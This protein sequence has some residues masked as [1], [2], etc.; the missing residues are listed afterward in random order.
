MLNKE[1]TGIV[2]L[3]SIFFMVSLFLG[4][5]FQK[6]FSQSST[7][8]TNSQEFEK[9]KELGKEGY[10]KECQGTGGIGEALGDSIC[11][12]FADVFE[13]EE[14]NSVQQNQTSNNTELQG[15][16]SFV[17]NEYGI[18][19]VYPGDWYQN[20]HSVAKGTREFSSDIYEAPKFSKFLLLG[21]P[22]F[23]KMW[24]DV[25]KDEPNVKV[26]DEPG[27]IFIGGEPAVSFSYSEGQKATM[28]AALLHNNI[29]Y[30]FQYK[31]QKENFD[32][33]MNIALDLFGSIKFLN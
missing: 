10:I 14:A 21:T 9:F 5:S 31:T 24:F 8:G 27:S 23:G 1:K 30:V 4:N 11:K 16:K 25:L 32:K 20:T 3:I 2:L 18:S 17:D 26:I 19:F 22:G 13:K 15:P 6:T 33:D 12:A 28:V 29:G 7:S